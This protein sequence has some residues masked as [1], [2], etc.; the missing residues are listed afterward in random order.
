[1][2]EWKPTMPT[3]AGNYLYQT[4]DLKWHGCELV[5]LGDFLAICDPTGFYPL[6]ELGCAIGW[7]GPIPNP[8]T[9]KES[10]RES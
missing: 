3:V 7:Y 1:M 5:D 2:S 8:T 4:A 10:E 6:S 9:V